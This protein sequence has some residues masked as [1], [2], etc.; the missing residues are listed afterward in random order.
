M[1]R[2]RRAEHSKRFAAAL[3]PESQ[4]LISD[5]LYYGP[6]LRGLSDALLEHD[7]IMRPVQCLQAYQ[8]QQFLE[9][10]AGFYV[11]VVFLGPLYTAREF[12]E[13]TVA[14]FSAPKVMLDHHFDDLPLH[15]V[16][17]DAAAGMRLLTEHLVSLGHRRIAYLDRGNPEANPWKREGVVQALEAAGLPAL[18]RG[19]SA[20][21][22]DNFADVAAAL[23][24]FVGLEPRPTAVI[25]FDDRRALLLLQA[26]AEKGIGVPE[27]LSIA[28]YGD[29]AVRTGRSE[30]LTSVQV[31]ADA[32]G[33]RAAD[34]V[35]G[36]P[37][38]EI[39]SVLVTPRLMARRSTTGPVG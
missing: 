4:A 24:W 30:I 37:R 19:W 20:G 34:L 3:L 14:K 13:R 10:A 9:T 21:C 17:D 6:M 18:G 27:D 1:A 35:V 28:G 26:A 22:R 36:D 39:Q 16:R 5:K 38:G 7:V 11:G 33:R 29:V 31:D 2:R 8:Q 25:C 12:I 15:S 32:M 23:D